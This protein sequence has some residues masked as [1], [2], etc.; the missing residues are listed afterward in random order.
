[1]VTGSHPSAVKVT[2]WVTMSGVIGRDQQLG[3]S[4]RT[5]GVASLATCFRAPHLLLQLSSRFEVIMCG[6]LV[7]DLAL[8]DRPFAA[9]FRAELAITVEVRLH[10]EFVALV[11]DEIDRPFAEVTRCLVHLFA[12]LA[13]ISGVLRGTR[14]CCCFHT[15]STEGRSRVLP[16]E[17]HR[18]AGRRESHVRF[19]LDVLVCCRSDTYVRAPLSCDLL[20]QSSRCD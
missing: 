4:C 6:L 13:V 11:H 19:V 12:S 16:S 8:R 10:H 7:G 20:V 9:S 18:G 3:T 5:G 15:T 2:S 1:M 17:G 14:A